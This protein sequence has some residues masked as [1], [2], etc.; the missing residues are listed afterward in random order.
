MEIRLLCLGEDR[1]VVYLYKSGMGSDDQKWVCSHQYCKTQQ[2]LNY[3]KVEIS[4]ELHD[5]QHISEFQNS[6]NRV[7]LRRSESKVF[8][9]AKIL[10]TK[11]RCFVQTS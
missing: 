1:G 7:Y 2:G 9:H 5:H 4:T 8:G 11:A 10:V 3:F 6:P